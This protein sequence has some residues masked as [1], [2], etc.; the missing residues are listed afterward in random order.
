MPHQFPNVLTGQAL[1]VATESGFLPSLICKVANTASATPVMARL[2]FDS[3]AANSFLTSELV[4][5]ADLTEDH[6]RYET[7]TGI[8]GKNSKLLIQYI[9]CYLIS[10]VDGTVHFANMRAIDQICSKLPPLDVDWVDIPE[11]DLLEVTEELPRAAVNVDILVGN[12]LFSTLVN[13]ARVAGESRQHLIWDTRLGTAVSGKSNFKVPSTNCNLPTAASNDQLAHELKQFW[14]WESL[15][16]IKDQV[17]LTPKE[18]Y[19]VEHFFNN[20]KYEGGRYQ[21]ALPF[22]PDMPKPKNNFGS[23]MAQFKSL[24][25][26]LCRNESKCLRYST[27]IEQYITDGHAERVFSHSPDKDERFFLPHHAIWRDNHPTTKARIVFNGSAGDVTGYTLNQSLLPGPKKQS[28]LSDVLTRYRTFE[29]TLTGDIAKMFLQIGILPE[30]RNYLSF[31]WRPPGSSGEVCVYRKTVLTFGLNCSPF[32]AIQTIEH[33]LDK[34][35]HMYPEAARLV[36]RQ[37]FV[38]DVLLGSA[39]IPDLIVLRKQITELLALGGFHFTKWLSNEAEVMLSVPEKDRAAAAPMVIAEKS[40]LLSIEAVPK[41]LGIMWDPLSDCFEFQGALDLI[42]PDKKETMRTLASRSAKVFDP[43]GLVSPVLIQ[44]KILMQRC[45]KEKLQWDNPL[46]AQILEP[47][48]EWISDLVHLHFLDVPR[49]LYIKSNVEVALHGFSDASMDACSAC[50]YART[51]NSEGRVQVTLISSKTKLAP[52]QT[53]T[54]PRLELMGA[55]LLAKLAHKVSK[56]LQIDNV[57]LWTDNTCVLQWLRQPASSWKTFVGNRVSQITEL[58]PVE[59]FRHVGTHENPADIASRGMAASKLIKCKDWFE[60]PHFLAEAEEFWPRSPI[61]AADNSEVTAEANAPAGIEAAV[62]L[63]LTVCTL[64]PEIMEQLFDNIRP[65]SRNLRLLALVL[66]FGYN[67][68]PTSRDSRRSNPYPSLYEHQLA[69]R[70]W[71][72]FV[73]EQSFQKELP[74][75]M[76]GEG[77]TKGPMRQLQPFF[78]HTSGLA[79]VGGRLHFSGLSE[80]AI[81]PA[82]LPAKSKYVE[83]YVLYLHRAHNHLGGEGLLAQIRTRFWLIQGRREVKR[84][85]WRC[86]ACYRQRSPPFAQSIAPLPS[87][88]VAATAAWL[89]IGIDYAGPFMV[90]REKIFPS[91]VEEFAKVWILLATD[92][93]TR[94][95]HLEWMWTMTTPHMINALQRLIARRGHPRV[96]YSDNALQFRKCDVELQRLYRHLDWNK[97]ERYLIK[98]PSQIEFRFSAPL[99]PHWGGVWER[100]VRSV[101]TALKSTLGNRRATLEEFRTVLLNAEALVNSRPLT[102]V[103][104]DHGDPLPITPAHL[105]QGR[106]LM[107]IPDFLSEDQWQTKVALQWKS[108]QKL[109]SEFWGRWRKEYLAALQP[110]QKWTRPGHEPQVG[111]V[112]LLD[113]EPRSRNEWPLARVLEV[114]PGRDGL[115]RSV[116]LFIKWSDKPIRRDVRKIYHFEESASEIELQTAELSSLA[117][118]RM[119]PKGEKNLPVQDGKVSFA[120]ATAT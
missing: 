61:P 88:R 109:H 112:V 106:S 69:L 62:A 117:A 111:E 99:A 26:S 32:I 97:I 81:H 60:G 63:A 16:I 108:R 43:L 116:L 2:V 45:W 119:N 115:V 75:L 94:A 96:I 105:S 120:S 118:S 25:R 1:F 23:A 80:E 84:I 42:I 36:R 9:S 73:Q 3:G 79:K 20:V 15:G 52:L 33:H 30:H 54:I 29:H 67:C 113:D 40:M 7:V 37:I 68:R 91:D 24:E 28:D 90:L 92:L 101:K 48:L 56:C 38:D 10:C 57:I 18:K 114:Y 103:S 98:L 39:S 11:V 100:M 53:A 49:H 77:M 89:F 22:D 64:D 95:V 93:A 8:G 6:R 74:P 82:F 14:N 110:S 70:A 59:H 78:D 46:P 41:T 19:V 65:F 13:G 5:R 86:K 50:I 104:D 34:F 27:A 58:F 87:G 102:L 55:L 35:E 72:I 107:Q 12:D 17:L 44:A 21:V 71:T 85:L 4:Q 66:R 76:A 47:W 31:L 51:V 83:S